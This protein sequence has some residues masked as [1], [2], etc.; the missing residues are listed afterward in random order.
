MMNETK[1][2]EKG[3]TFTSYHTIMAQNDSY[4]LHWS[5]GEDVRIRKG[6]TSLETLNN[7][8]EDGNV[9]VEAGEQVVL[10]SV[11]YKKT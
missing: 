9:V 8:T 7:T 3:Y 10:Q 4:T 1:L 11:W 2:Q 6:V 5:G